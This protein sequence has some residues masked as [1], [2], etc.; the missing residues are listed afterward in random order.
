MRI[1]HTSDLHLN[2]K[3]NSKLS[4]EKARERKRELL[5]N[6]RKMAEC[7]KENGIEA[8][9][10]AG[11]LFD[12]EK[13]S[14]SVKKSAM[15]IIAEKSEISFYYLPGNH[16]KDSLSSE[17]EL[18]GNLKIFGEDWTYFIQ[19]GI[20]FAGRSKTAPGMFESFSA[21]EGAECVIAVLHGELRERS[22]EGGIIGKKELSER[23]IDYLALG[24]YHS[25]SKEE[26]EKG[27]YAVYSG[28][29]MGRGF[30]ECGEKGFVIIEAKNNNVKFSFQKAYNREL[31]DQKI[32][33]NGLLGTQ[34]LLDKILHACR[35]IP[36]SSLLRCTLT[37]ERKP[38]AQFDTDFIKKRLEDSFYYFEIKD[39][40]RLEIRPLD[41]ANDKTLKGEFIRLVLSDEKL[42]DEEKKDIIICGI[43]ALLGEE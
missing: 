16:E 30:D 35:D 29:P 12:T 7:A 34:E 43:S 1:I 33:L 31:I 18:P 6:F 38:E 39:E 26:F 9:I 28:T 32:E 15:D 19:D 3:M 25:Y 42:T 37:G 41:Y 4:K 24:H 21:P 13:I 22:A 11:D 8:F 20:C 17:K 40:S 27:K 36:K 14:A 10:I 2:S 5:L 23:G